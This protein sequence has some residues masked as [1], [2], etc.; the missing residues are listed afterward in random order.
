M[1][2]FNDGQTFSLL[3]AG[4]GETREETGGG[5]GVVGRKDLMHDG[6]RSII[7]DM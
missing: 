6:Q 3:G 1:V 7:H 5:L 2:T 4:A